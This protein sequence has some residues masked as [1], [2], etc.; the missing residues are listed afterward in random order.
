MSLSEKESAKQPRFTASEF[1][2][3]TLFWG[4]QPSSSSSLS[5]R[6]SACRNQTQWQSIYGC[7]Q[8][9]YR[10]LGYWHLT[11][12]DAKRERIRH[13]KK[14]GRR[15]TKMLCVLL[16]FSVGFISGQANVPFQ[17]RKQ[18]KTEKTNFFLF[19]F[20]NPIKSLPCKGK[21]EMKKKRENK[22]IYQ[23]TKARFV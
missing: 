1:E 19:F 10:S 8:H 12:C 2:S 17:K 22:M 3:A 16:F 9:V 20:S 5:R 21:K 4:T 13:Q 14:P 23:W 18:K 11:A 15:S 6:Y 7:R